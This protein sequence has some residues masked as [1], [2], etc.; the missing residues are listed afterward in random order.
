MHGTLYSQMHGMALPSSDDPCM[1]DACLPAAIS[2]FLSLLRCWPFNL[3]I[4]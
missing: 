4:S 3:S 2:F 1:E